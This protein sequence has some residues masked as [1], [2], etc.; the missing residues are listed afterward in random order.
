MGR[1]KEGVRAERIIGGMALWV[2]RMSSGRKVGNGLGMT[3]GLTT[4]STSRLLGAVVMVSVVDGEVRKL[5]GIS[6]AAAILPRRRLYAFPIEFD[7]N[8]YPLIA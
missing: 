7:P 2:G 3:D 4:V 1:G 5:S 8:L 6:I